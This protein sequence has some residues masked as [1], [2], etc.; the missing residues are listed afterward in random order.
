MQIELTFEHPLM[1][2]VANLATFFSKKELAGLH[3]S[4]TTLA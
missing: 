4:L 3:K 2:Q 1:F